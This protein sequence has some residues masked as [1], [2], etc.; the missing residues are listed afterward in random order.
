MTVYHNFSVFI[1]IKQ[2]TVKEGK[3]FWGLDLK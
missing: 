3:R 1:T 2:N